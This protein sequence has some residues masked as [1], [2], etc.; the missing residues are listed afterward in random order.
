M[1]NYSH[2]HLSELNNNHNSI[3]YF[4]TLFKTECPKYHRRN[5][6]LL[7]VRWTRRERERERE[8]RRE[9]E[10][11]GERERNKRIKH[12]NNIIPSLTIDLIK[13]NSLLSLWHVKWKIIIGYLVGRLMNIWMAINLLMSFDYL[14]LIEI[15][16]YFEDKLRIVYID[17]VILL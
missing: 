4:F 7:L 13:K 10:K 2:W 11:E 8:R 5:Q 16:N 9:R 6:Q 1:L 14:T 3:E 12:E 15:V 17:L